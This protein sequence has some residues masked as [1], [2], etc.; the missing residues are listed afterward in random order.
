[1][2]DPHCPICHGARSRYTGSR[3]ECCPACV[4]CPACERDAHVERPRIV[5]GFLLV[6]LLIHILAVAF[7]LLRH[8]GVLP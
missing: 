4:N 7:A 5:G 1:M 6:L 8:W 3:R 2:S